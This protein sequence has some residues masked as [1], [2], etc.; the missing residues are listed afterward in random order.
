MNQI[1]CAS[2]GVTLRNAGCLCV[3]VFLLVMQEPRT[4]YCQA[5]TWQVKFNS[6]KSLSHVSRSGR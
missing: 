5:R 2:P 6:G 4:M 1:D 3:V